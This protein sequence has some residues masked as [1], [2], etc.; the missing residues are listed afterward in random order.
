MAS[1]KLLLICSSSSLSRC[2]FSIASISFLQLV[3]PG[4]DLLVLGQIGF[5]L[6]GR[7]QRHLGLDVAEDRRLERV[8]VLLPDRIELVVVAARA[9]DRQAQRALADRPENLVEIVVAALGI[10]LL[11]EQHARPGAQESGGDEAV[12]GLAVHLVA[13]N[14]FGQEDVVRFVGVERRESRSRDSARRSGRWTSYSKPARVGVSRHIEPVTAVAFAV[15]RRGQQLVDE[16]LPRAGRCIRHERGDLG[17]RRR[18]SEQIE[19]RAAHERQAI[20]PRRRRQPALGARL[21][22]EAIDRVGEILAVDDGSGACTGS[23]NAQ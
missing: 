1:E 22:Q 4:V 20:G 17:R 12:F 3:P 21:L 15:V 19:I 16:A 6:G 23:L 9:V 11:A 10:V 7:R 14:L 8:V 13:G 5:R 2:G 18:Q